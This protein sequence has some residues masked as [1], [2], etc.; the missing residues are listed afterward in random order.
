M[1]ESDILHPTRT[2][3]EKRIGFVYGEQV[4]ELEDILSV[5]F[6]YELNPE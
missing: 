1:L 5:L 4:E 3:I 6:S 2:A